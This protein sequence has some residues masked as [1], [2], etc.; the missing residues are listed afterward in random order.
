MRA[1]E[2]HNSLSSMEAEAERL[3]AAE[4]GLMAMDAQAAGRDELYARAEVRM[5]SQAVHAHGGTHCTVYT[6]LCM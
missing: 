6:V 2:V 4:R 1:Q 5:G 3:A